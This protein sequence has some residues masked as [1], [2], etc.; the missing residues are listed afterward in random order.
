MLLS[1]CIPSY[2]RFEKLKETID[3]ILKATSNDFEIVIVD[4]CSTDDIFNYIN[5]KDSRLR[6]VQRDKPV[7]G[8][9]NVGDAILYGRGVYS[10]LLLDKD[11]ILGEKLDAFINVLSRSDVMGG[12]CVLNSKKENIKITEKE[13]IEHFG[14]LSKHPSGNFY[15]IDPIR[16]YINKKA[17]LLEKAAFPFDT[18]L[19]Y[20]ASLGSMMYF[21]KPLV[22][23]AL[24]DFSKDDNRGSLTFS[25]DAGNMYYFPENRIDEFR[26]FATCLDELV[27]DKKEKMD[28]FVSLYK[29]TV[30]YVSKGYREIMKNKDICNHYHHRTEDIGL[31]KMISFALDFRRAFY[32][33]Q[34][35]SI[36]NVDKKQIERRVLKLMLFKKLMA[37]RSRL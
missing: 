4:N 34:F 27:I 18:Y 30:L 25:K 2:N 36:N 14:F 20:C 1:I 29:R 16:D 26:L 8:A 32:D 37:K 6:I 11:T 15:K 9:K 13:A 10:L 28:I 23:S 5:S 35:N 24:A 31:K 12:Y 22:C 17:K 7:Y 33:I 19:A 21:D 3:D